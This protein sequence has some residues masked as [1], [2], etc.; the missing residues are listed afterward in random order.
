MNLMFRVE[1]FLQFALKNAI[2]S[3]AIPCPC[4]RCGNLR[5]K[6]VETI[7]AHL[8]CNGMD[9]TYH[10]WIWHGEISTKG[11]SMNDDDRVGQDEHKS[12]S[13]E[14]LDMVHCVYESYAENPSQFNKLLEDADK[15]LYP[16]CAKFTKLSAVVKLFNLKA[17]YSWSDKSF[18][19][20][21][22]LFGEML[23]DHNE[24]PSS[25]YDAKKS[26]IALGME[27]VKI[28]ACPNDCILYRKEYEEFANCP[29][30]RTSRWKLG[31][32]SKVKEGIP[33]KV[34]WYFPSIPRFQ[35]MFRNK[36]I[37]KELTWHT[38]KRIRDGYLRHP[39]DS[40]SW[41]LVDRMWPDFA[42]EPKNLRLAISADGINPHSLMS[43]AYSCWPVLIITY[44]L[45]PWLCMKRKFVMLSLLISGPRQPG[46][47]I[48]VY[49]AP[50]IDD[51]KCLWDKGVEAYD[52]YREESFSLR[53]VLLWTINVFPAYGNMSECVVKGYREEIFSLR[54]V[55][56]C[57]RAVSEIVILHICWLMTCGS[58]IQMILD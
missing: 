20:L 26:L 21:L 22:I 23:P 39:A 47:V 16:G 45:S 8:Y 32:K 53:S 43:S 55:L 10:T 46:N 31:N 50:L 37:S 40:P 51:L 49:L 34:L 2:H 6:N 56:T 25:L 29:S 30:C 13:E 57:L 5:K 3:D 7:R 38:N 33:A 28:P 9:L 17:K 4:A 1:S 52:A 19:D 58:R 27:Y 48:D 35:R 15:P 36:A 41:K 44:N 42:Y 11:N 12:F 54:A 24:L 14:H 18:A